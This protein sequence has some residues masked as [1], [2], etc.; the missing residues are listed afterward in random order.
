MAAAQCN[1]RAKKPKS[2]QANG[3]LN[4]S[5][6]GSAN[7]HL[8][9]FA[10]KSN[11]SSRPTRGQR[12]QRTL[13]GALMSVFGRL[14]TWYIIITLVFR[15]PSSL[16]QIDDASPRV[17]TPYLQARSYATPYLDPYYQTYL[18]PHVE[19]VKPYADRFERQI[20]TPAATFT[21]DK[22]AAYGAHRVEQAKNQAVAGWDKAVRPHLQTA[23]DK[24]QDQ[25][26][27]YLGPHV[28]KAS[29]AAAPYYS[30]TRDGLNT[31]YHSSVLPTYKASLPYLR[32][33][34][35]QGHYLVADI[36]F[37][38]V[39]A[40]KDFTWSFLV[41]SVWPQLRVLYGDNVEPQLVRISER[42]GR[43]RDQQK[44]ESAADA[45]GSETSTVAADSTEIVPTIA[46]SSASSSSTADSGWGVLDGLLGVASSS[47]TS[48]EVSSE[49]KAETAAE[50]KLTGEALRERLNE[51]LRKW[52]TKFAVAA[53]KG[54]EDLEHRV[55]EITERQ[56][57]NGVKGHGR[58]L[59]VKLEETADSTITSLKSFIKRTV[60]S[61]AEDATEEDLEAAYEKCSTKARELG[62]TVK[63]KAQDVRVW[64]ASYDQ[65]T[66][67]L[68][69]AAVRSTVEVLEKI[70][71]LAFKRLACVGHGL[72]VSLTTIGKTTTS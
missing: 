2:T 30:Q 28:Q 10:D 64:K 68:V 65:E 22:Y 11:F 12:K 16:I 42:L 25:Y 55:A 44:M 38:N 72:T 47:S 9:G 27:A 43:Y 56:V 26:D 1:G 69:Q 59:V 21:K 17:C 67:S 36:I 15:C 8:N 49:T 13:M 66:D 34:R 51:D 70:H 54:A 18:A 71:G 7:G 29:D 48:S 46:A 61:I 14:V 41:R 4:G 23:Q 33:A 58:A 37:P 57:E 35:V 19:K 6:N 39:H 31:V 53:D 20:Y 24:V 5:L 60:E 3:S 50:P 45:A 52:Q 32:K 62:L 40:A 63:D